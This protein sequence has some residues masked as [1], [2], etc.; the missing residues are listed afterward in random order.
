MLQTLAAA[1]IPAL[2]LPVVARGGKPALAST[3]LRAPVPARESSLQFAIDFDL[4]ETAHR[5]LA[6]SFRTGTQLSLYADDHQMDGKVTE[7]RFSADPGE[8]MKVHLTIQ[9]QWVS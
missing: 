5:T 1:A 2:A 6:D 8:A 3:F 7:F 9:G 4:T